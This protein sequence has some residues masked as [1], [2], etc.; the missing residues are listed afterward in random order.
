MTLKALRAGLYSP[1]MLADARAYVKKC[2][3]CQRFTPI[4]NQLENDLQPILNPILFAQWRMDIIGPFAPASWGRKFPIVG[5]DCFIKW[6]EA[7]PA[8]KITANQLKKF[9]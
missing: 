6:I 4:I 1:T 3:K 5:I 7:E 9:V 2:D 8:A